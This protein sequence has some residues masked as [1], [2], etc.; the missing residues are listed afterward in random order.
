MRLIS[1]GR[2]TNSIWEKAIVKVFIKADCTG[3]ESINCLRVI[4]T[5]G[6][7]NR[8]QPHK[9]WTWTWLDNNLLLKYNWLFCLSNAPVICAGMTIFF[10]Q[11]KKSQTIGRWQG[12]SVGR[13]LNSRPEDPRFKPRQEQKKN[14]FF[15][16]KCC[17]DSLSN[18]GV[19]TQAKEWSRTH[20]KD[21]AGR[22]RV[23]W[24]METWKYPTCT[25]RT[26]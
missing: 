18:L 1:G 3:H 22:I 4:Q 9:V 14:S 25:C 19:Y 24:I 5:K 8:Q 16:Q 10:V 15:S 20:V 12:G 13:A 26:G 21:P 11:I 23:P 17:A 6:I 2:V 7:E